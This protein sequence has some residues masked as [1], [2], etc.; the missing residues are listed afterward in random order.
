M[1]TPPLPTGIEQI[2]LD[3]AWAKLQKDAAQAMH[4][5]M[6]THCPPELQPHL[7]AYL[8]EMSPPVVHGDEIPVQWADGSTVDGS[9]AIA[10][11]TDTKLNFVKLTSDPPEP[12]VRRR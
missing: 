9:P 4:E 3:E 7:Q 6:N 5:Y 12:P 1:A 10:D 11:V 2:E 8:A